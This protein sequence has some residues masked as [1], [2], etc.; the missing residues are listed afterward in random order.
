MA[1]P[2]G[3]YETVAGLIAT[4]LGRIPVEGDC[5]QVG[6]WRLDVLDVDHHRADRVQIT[7]PAR[8]RQQDFQ[9]AR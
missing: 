3:P 8:L 5:L 6:G 7:A 4:R 2:D 9:E 1:A